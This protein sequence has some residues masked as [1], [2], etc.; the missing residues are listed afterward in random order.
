MS[1]V[2]RWAF[3]VRRS[4]F[5]VHP[6]HALQARASRGV[7]PDGLGSPACTTFLRGKLLDH[8]AIFVG[9]DV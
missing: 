6:V 1:D 2:R 5:V 8:R 4:V 9:Q 3:E 7:V